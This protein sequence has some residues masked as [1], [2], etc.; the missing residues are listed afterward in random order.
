MS[1]TSRDI[2]DE[3]ETP[4]VDP[5]SNQPNHQGD[6]PTGALFVGA[7]D[8][9]FGI[10]TYNQTLFLVRDD[11]KDLLWSLTTDSEKSTEQNLV[12]RESGDPNWVKSK[13]T[14][15]CVAG[16]PRHGTERETAMRLLGLLVRA[17]FHF[18]FPQPPYLPGLLTCNELADVVD[19]V[20]AA[21]AR[22][23]AAAETE[24]R[25][26]SAPIIKVARDLDLNPRPAG[27]NDKDWLADCPTSR[28]HWIMISPSA[29]HFGCGYCRR[30]GGPAD[31][32]AFADF[33][34]TSRGTV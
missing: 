25:L 17:M 20:I 2:L 12:A 7:W 19:A 32:R 31:L 11:R 21:F 13:V 28:S 23:R 22:N 15:G 34:R 8:V 5:W 27:H 1:D 4:F 9:N 3:D 33:V 18:E 10:E 16:A 6:V 30:N 29:N 24:Q 14:C 26:N